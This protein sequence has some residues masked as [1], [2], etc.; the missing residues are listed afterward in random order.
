MEFDE[1]PHPEQIRIECWKIQESWTDQERAARSGFLRVEEQSATV[2][3]FLVHHR[4]R[5]GWVRGAVRSVAV[6]RCVDGR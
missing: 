3:Q 1:L 5:G 4:E 6:W 2:K